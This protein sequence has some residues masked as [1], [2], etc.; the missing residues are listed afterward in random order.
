MCFL[1]Y[2]GSN[3]VTN[4]LIKV[5][6]YEDFFKSLSRGP[7]TGKEGLPARPSKE[8]STDHEKVNINPLTR[9]PI[10]KRNSKY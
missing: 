7:V 1:L 2:K 10:W 6:N 3:F 5:L 8:V 9:I 4:S